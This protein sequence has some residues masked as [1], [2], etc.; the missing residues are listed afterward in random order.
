M[1]VIPIRAGRHPKLR[2]E[3]LLAPEGLR[4]SNGYHFNRVSV[5]TIVQSFSNHPPHILV[6]QILPPDT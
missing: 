3:R 5:C 1:G 6:G 2:V 4:K